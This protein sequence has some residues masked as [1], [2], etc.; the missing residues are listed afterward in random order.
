ML[1]LAEAQNVPYR[2]ASRSDLEQRASGNNH[3][4]IVAGCVLATGEPLANESYLDQIL[5][6]LT[7]P[8]LFL[9]LDEVTDPHNLGACLRTA[10]AAGVDA[11]IT[12]R[13]RS[14]GITPVVRKVACG[15]AET[16]PFVMVTNL[17]R[18]LRMLREQGVWL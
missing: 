4:G 6:T 15:A 13:D 7:G 9:V 8:A 12:T 3:Q 2:W 18:T 11:V 5:Q 10:D 14:V 17:A 1:S 16:V